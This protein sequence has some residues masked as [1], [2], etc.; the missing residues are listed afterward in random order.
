MQSWNEPPSTRLAAAQRGFVYW[1]S[2]PVDNWQVGSLLKD[3]ATGRFEEKSAIEFAA[4]CAS[5]HGDA[6]GPPTH[7]DSALLAERPECRKRMH[8][9]R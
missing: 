8:R 4:G 3:N 9:K 6:G 5:Q 7:R 2:V 1:H